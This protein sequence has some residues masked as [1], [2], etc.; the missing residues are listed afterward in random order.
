MNKN[1]SSWFLWP[2]AEQA[3]L[4]VLLALWIPPACALWLWSRGSVAL[5]ALVCITWLGPYVWLLR[6]LDAKRNVR[7][8]VSIPASIAALV[9]AAF[10]LG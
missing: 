9:V 10:F 1:E 2:M 8:V 4:L 6:A 7:F 5:A 3:L